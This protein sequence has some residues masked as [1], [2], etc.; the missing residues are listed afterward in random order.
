MIEIKK[1]RFLWFNLIWCITSF[2]IPFVILSN[3]TDLHI[4]WVIAIS[5]YIYFMDIIQTTNREYLSVRI[6]RL[7]ETISN[8]L[9][10]KIYCKQSNPEKSGWYDT[11]DGNIYWFKNNEQWSSRDDRVSEEY[12]TWWLKS[13]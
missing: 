3:F 4:F 9:S 6:D 2:I 1:I 13:I 5:S 7:E 10:K 8:T 12:P 11:N